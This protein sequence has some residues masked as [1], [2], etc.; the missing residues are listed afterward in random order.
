MT[1]VMTATYVEDLLTPFSL[2]TA[3]AAMKAA[4]QTQL[5][6][7][8]SDEVLAL[9]LAKTALE[10]GR[11]K[12]IHRYNW[13]NVKAG[14]AYVGMYTAFACNEVLAG[15]LV[16]FSPRGR[17]DKQ[18]GVVVAEHYDGEPWHPQTRF[19]AYANEYDGSYEYVAL[20]A[21]GRYKKAWAALLAGSVSGF[22]HELKLAGYFTA[23]EAL[24]LKGVSGLYQEMLARVRGLPH[25]AHVPEG[26]HDFERILATIRG[27]QFAHAI[28]LAGL[29]HDVS[30]A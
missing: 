21:N 14:A 10:T 19:R 18:G 15:K 13:G 8:P 27:D 6:R 26:D 7:A 30:Y 25:E 1:D 9:A 2:E 20:I 24:Y 4:L 16:W 11:Y 23:D 29:D 22:V 3:A 28:D 17:L 12:S 5:G